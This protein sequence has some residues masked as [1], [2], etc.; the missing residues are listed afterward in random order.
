[1][2]SEKK[3]GLKRKINK[4][5]LIIALVT[6][7][8]VMLI[9]TVVFYE[10]FKAEVMNDLKTCT[11]ILKDTGVFD[12]LDDLDEGSL[13]D[14]DMRI[15]IISASGDVVYDSKADATDMAN[16]ENRPEIEEA[17]MSGEGE[18]V[19]TSETLNKNTF[20][21]AI[22]L[23]DGYVLRTSKESSSIWIVFANGLPVLLA[24]ILLLV[25]ATIFVTDYLTRSIVKPI[26][27]MARDISKVDETKCYKEM[28]PFINTIKR[29]HEDILQNAQMRQ[30]F[31][32][33]VSHELKT[34]LTSISGYSEL[35]E[36]GMAAEEDI[37]R[38]AHEIHRNSNRL[39]T[40]I[41]D[42]IR[43]SELDVSENDTSMEPV[44]LYTIAQTAV[45]MQQMNAEK[46]NISL[47][48][49][50]SPALINANKMM[51]EELVYNL[52]D[53]AIRYNNENGSVICKVEKLNDAVILLVKDTGIGI[54]KEHQ[55]RI[56]ERFYRV[57]KSRSKLT[58]GT[59]LGLA[60]VKHIVAQHDAEIEVDSEPGVGT[61]I[62]VIFPVN[63]DKI[64]E[65]P[66]GS[67]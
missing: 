1:M 20:Y 21:Y 23:D 60:I 7:V 49:T 44:D 24:I 8:A 37:R 64:N 25:I 66:G 34:P 38:F 41:N 2:K 58:G 46:H 6:I 29:Q 33:N 14:E 59:G 3:L 32:A 63:K 13:A 15:T 17:F 35:I 48:M 61:E 9:S 67:V 50:G 26:E 27:L 43:L 22:L 56:F 5:F 62:K 42:I 4:Y 12:A 40:L 47:S 19:R 36:N 45:D 31:T 10:L 39:L 30:E 18:D 11:H 55:E 51:M 65:E 57:D 28:Q 52:T 53:N 16:H 54:P